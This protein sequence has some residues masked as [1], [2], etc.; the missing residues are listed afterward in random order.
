MT[1]IR[2]GRG[3]LQVHIIVSML[4]S[5]LA[6][7]MTKSTVQAAD[8]DKKEEII[9]TVRKSEELLRDVP[10]SI[11]AISAD[12]ITELNLTNTDDIGRFT[13]GLSYTSA[14]GRQPGSD[15]PT[16]RGLTTI[17]NGF[18]NVSSVGTFVDGIYVGGSTQTTE[19]WN[20][21]R[22]EIMRGPQAAL[23]GRGTY[24]GAINY[25]TRKP[26]DEFEGGVVATAAEHDSYAG[27]AWVS[28]PIVSDVLSFYVGAGYDTYGG[29]WT[30]NKD[31]SDIGGEETTGVTG[32]LYWT[33]TENFDAALKLGYQQTDD[34][35]FA[36]YLQS[37]DLN[38]C[39]FRTAE[40]PR[41]REYYVG[42]AIPDE[43]GVNLNTDVL[44]AAG[45]VGT[46]IDR[47]IASLSLNW[48][49]IDG[50]QLTS[51]TG[52]IDDDI[53]TG[54]D[55]SYAGYE[56]FTV[57]ASFNG[58][59]NQIDHDEQSDLSQELRIS[60]TGD[61]AINWS[62]GVYYYKGESEQGESL[63][64]TQ[65]GEV[66]RN[67][68]VRNNSLEEIENIAAFGGVY[69]A[70]SDRWDTSFELRYAEDEIT[71]TNY[72]N[73]DAALFV[74]EYNE[75]FKSVTPRLTATF[76]A[77]D[78][79]NIYGNISKGTK[80]GAFNSS[81][82]D[83]INGNPDES[84][85]DVDEEEV[86]SYELGTKMS[87]MDQRVS[88]S[89][90][91]YYMDV[92]DQQL[93]VVIEVP[94]GGGTTSLL[95]NA[96][97]TE[98]YG[99]ELETN[100]MITENLTGGFSYAYTHAEIKERI[101][102]DEADLQ[103]SDGSFEQN[104]ALG[105][106]A[107]R[108]VPRVPDHMLSLFGRYEHSLSSWGAWYVGGDYTFESA[109]YAQEHNLIEN[110][111]RNLVGARAGLLV[112]NWD[113]SIWGKNVLD[114]DTPVDV[115]RYIDRRSGGLPPFPQNGPRPSSSP[116][117]FGLTLP[118]GRQIGATMNYRF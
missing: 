45:T 118:R 81:V 12:S 102:Q 93:T 15:R 61:G 91:G 103:G 39:C 75:T 62:A 86:L 80:P 19:L 2:K 28:G 40:A 85:R 88:L 47:T 106:V 36:I 44:D 87:L 7:P 73:D 54:Y 99:V 71:L 56:P 27:N 67:P 92:E 90:A 50:Y 116:R 58:G 37:R 70:I 74:A 97:K 49:F 59:F 31:G 66:K 17:R 51:L 25:V 46:E 115:I 21:E 8:V 114:D 38:N 23:F 33:P 6:L 57:P 108:D 109:K 79:I 5:M 110:G 107:G 14:F 78:D 82:P 111:D 105:N 83:D 63:G 20:L 68:F 48:E 22:V 95:Q 96:G 53:D 69:W 64:V 10:I 9:V 29:E 43:N 26:S 94:G 24:G 35:H 76:A 104:Q 55:Q 11:T 4:V 84:F 65:A 41:A 100:V 60:T 34:D 32:K 3:K 72:A 89:L 117:G 18:A 13:P 101:S 98:I 77:T 30:N 42:T 113:F 112:G 52:Y 1:N 16:M